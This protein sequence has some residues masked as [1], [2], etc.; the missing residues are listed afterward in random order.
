MRK[1]F[2]LVVDDPDD[3]ECDCQLVRSIGGGRNTR[4]RLNNNILVVDVLNIPT[5]SG[6]GLVTINF[7][8]AS[9]SEVCAL[10]L[11]LVRTHCYHRR[12]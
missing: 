4:G 5:L 1:G 10:P 8:I 2:K 6:G 7:V 12:A 3:K 9:G 11:Y